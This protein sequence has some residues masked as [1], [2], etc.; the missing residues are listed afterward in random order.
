MRTRNKVNL[1]Q[2]GQVGPATQLQYSYPAN[3]FQ[4]TNSFGIQP[5]VIIGSEEET[6]IDD[7]TKSRHSKYV[8][9]EKRSIVR[10]YEQTD[11]YHTTA[12]RFQTGGLGAHWLTWGIYGDV[13]PSN[14]PVIWPSTERNL[15]RDTYAK[16]LSLNEVDNLLNVTDN[17]K[18]LL[19]GPIE[20]AKRFLSAQQIHTHDRK[21]IFRSLAR[22]G[23]VLSGG[24]LYYSF[25]VR[26]VVSDMRKIASHFGKYS[27][28][29]KAAQRR[30]GTVQTVHGKMKGHFGTSLV[31]SSD[32]PLA[33]SYRAVANTG[34][35][36]RADIISMIQPTMTCSI[37]GIRT[38][39]YNT[40]FFQNLDSLVSRF[41][42]TGPASYLWER[43][44]YS[45]VV[46]WF[47][48]LSTVTRSIDNALTG[49]TMRVID[50]SISEKWSC[51]AA[52]IKQSHDGTTISTI[53]GTQTALNELSYYTRKPIQPNLSIGLSGNF[54]KKQALLSSALLYQL[55]AKLV[56]RR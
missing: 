42:A 34:G 40:K 16:F 17:P 45:F 2:Y 35:I 5:S 9:H 8:K 37:K 23:S 26:P 12:N 21:T 44:P 47:L 50:A 49:N 43:I 4:G 27:D 1:L 22:H 41:G 36:W 20:L 46:D 52:V 25:G 6:M 39:R 54:G 30:A 28:L 14:I 56:D 33:P 51:L 55:V 7:R 18:G 3:A 15:I 24:F 32:H 31:T 29:L 48:D 19:T 11:E 38:E 10:T 13:Y 53:D